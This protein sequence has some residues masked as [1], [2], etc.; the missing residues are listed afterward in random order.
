MSV[1][2]SLLRKTILNP[3]Y[4]AFMCVCVFVVCSLYKPILALNCRLQIE[5]VNSDCAESDDGPL[6]LACLSLCFFSAS[7]ILVASNWEAPLLVRQRQF[8]VY[9][10][11]DQYQKETQV[12][13]DL[14]ATWAK[15]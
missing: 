13:N 4:Y 3:E 6:A 5:Q 14:H 15:F 8:Q 9:R 10:H 2:L 1:R 7:Q 11:P 12:P